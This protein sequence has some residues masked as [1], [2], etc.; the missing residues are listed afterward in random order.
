MTKPVCPTCGRTMFQPNPTAPTTADP[1]ILPELPSRFRLNGV[2]VEI[3]S[4]TDD[5]G[6]ATSQIT[7]RPL[8]Y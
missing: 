7:V 8:L 2:P 5:D 4:I 6:T 3:V 1:Y